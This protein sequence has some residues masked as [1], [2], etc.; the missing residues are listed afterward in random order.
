MVHPLLLHQKANGAFIQRD[1][2]S[3]GGVGF[4]FVFGIKWFVFPREMDCWETFVFS[5]KIDLKY[6]FRENGCEV[7]RGGFKFLV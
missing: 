3:A 1:F 7:L 4:G 2:E 6:F 5:R